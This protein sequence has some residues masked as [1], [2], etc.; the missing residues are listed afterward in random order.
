M[1][2]TVI[3]VIR[4]I[5][6]V[7]ILGLLTYGGFVG[8]NRVSGTGDYTIDQYAATDDG[9]L[10]TVTKGGTALHVKCSADQLAVVET[11]PDGTFHLSFSYS[12]TSATA[13]R[14]ASPRSRILAIDFYF[15]RRHWFQAMSQID[16]VTFQSDLLTYRTM[17]QHI[18]NDIRQIFLGHQFFLIPQFDDT[19]RHLTHRILVQ[20][21]TEVL[22][23][24]TDVRLA[25]G[26]S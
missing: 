18:G 6:I 26:L 16:K 9:G 7:A 15:Q 17:L 12:Q 4:I 8:M 3:T 22:Q 2:K 20:F 24:L 10:L 13:R 25:T 21:Q 1:K 11:Q 23:I 14:S 19:L 5:V